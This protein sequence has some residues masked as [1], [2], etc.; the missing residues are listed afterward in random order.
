V[1]DM[2]FV[3]EIGA[4]GGGREVAGVG[5]SSGLGLGFTSFNGVLCT[6][7]CN[8][9]LCCGKV[10]RV[11]LEGMAGGTVVERRERLGNLVED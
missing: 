1:V 4:F 8:N 9:T 10:G 11:A 5:G 2:E 3:V 6:N 7:C